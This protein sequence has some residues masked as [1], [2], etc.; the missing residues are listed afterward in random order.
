MD[1]VTHNNKKHPFVLVARKP[2][3]VIHWQPLMDQEKEKCG[4]IDSKIRG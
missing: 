3:S 4:K 1:M 2:K